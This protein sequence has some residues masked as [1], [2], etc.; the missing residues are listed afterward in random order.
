MQLKEFSG[1]KL[2]L[3]VAIVMSGQYE[4]DLDNSD[5]VVYT[6]Q[7]GNDLLGNKRQISDQAMVRGNLGLKV[8]GV[9]YFLR[10][11]LFPG[12]QNRYIRRVDRQCLLLDALN[13]SNGC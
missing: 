9:F 12:P 6:G 5:E 7:G 4:D 1:Y 2:P 11:T 10:C 8:T 3:A 13:I